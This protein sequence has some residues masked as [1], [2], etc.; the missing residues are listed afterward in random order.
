MSLDE[1]LGNETWR[2]NKRAAA[3]KI[4]KTDWEC[5]FC[6]R[7]LP[8]NTKG[9]HLRTCKLNPDRKGT[10]RR[11]TKRH[12]LVPCEYCKKGISRA[13][14]DTHVRKTCRVAQAIR[15]GRLVDATL[16]KA[17]LA[18]EVPAFEPPVT[19]GDGGQISWVVDS[20]GVGHLSFDVEADGP[21][22][23]T[24]L[25]RSLINMTVDE[26]IAD[27]KVRPS[28]S[29]WGRVT[30]AIDQLVRVLEQEL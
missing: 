16:M 21:E 10:Y 30:S 29:S 28:V 6:H 15:E 17:G 25:V 7:H 19:V 13:A 14:L 11:G 20:A 22:F 18:P 1:S 26:I 2:A 8:L 23:D 4:A 12:D 5:Q 9:N 3:Q 24:D 27:R